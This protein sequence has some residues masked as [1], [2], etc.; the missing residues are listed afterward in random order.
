MT[1]RRITL[2]A[3]AAALVT[4]APA[5][6]HGPVDPHLRIVPDG[7]V[8]ATPEV[9]VVVAQ[10]LQGLPPLMTVRNDGADEVVVLAPG[11]EPLFRIGPNGVLGNVRSPSYAAATDPRGILPMPKPRAG[12]GPDWR[13]LETEPVWRWYEDRAAYHG[14]IPTSVAGRR[15]DLEL[16]RWTVPVLVGGRPAAIAGRVL[17]HP[18]LGSIRQRIVET[19]WDD[20]RI[21]VKALPG[22]IPGIEVK[23]SSPETLEI[24]GRDD[25]PFARVGPDGVEVN[26]SSPTYTDTQ[27]LPE[28]SGDAPVWKHKQDLPVLV[29]L[30][31]RAAYEREDPPARVS[32]EGREEVL[33]RW[34]IPA[35]LG[36]RRVFIEGET[37]WAPFRSSSSRSPAPWIGAA[38]ALVLLGGL[39]ALRLRARSARL[40]PGTSVSSEA[41]AGRG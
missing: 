33:E 4:A 21:S 5:G 28:P 14:T 31:R 32:R 8:P 15:T 24:T 40:D 26:L 38:A 30:E 39:A 36:D 1:R 23:N 9:R 22:R 11:R 10:E 17:W 7:V 6:A 13:Q 19:G 25:R 3:L 37:Y 2:A 41:G 12:S 16:T 35:R 34:Q 18:L 27:G 20:D 29:W